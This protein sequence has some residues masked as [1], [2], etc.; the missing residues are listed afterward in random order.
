MTKFN[1]T[2]RQPT[3]MRFLRVVRLISVVPMLTVGVASKG[4][5]FNVRHSIT[6][7]QLININGQHTPFP[8]RFLISYFFVTCSSTSEPIF[9]RKIVVGFMASSDTVTRTVYARTQ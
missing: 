1:E 9:T 4:Y 3:T 5:M 2:E 8:S 7:I 6:L